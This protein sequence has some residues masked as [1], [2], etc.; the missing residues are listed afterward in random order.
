MMQRT[1]KPIHHAMKIREISFFSLQA[2]I[3]TIF[4]LLPIGLTLAIEEDGA[5]S[6][7]TRVAD[8]T[9]ILIAFTMLI[10]LSQDLKESVRPN[11]HAQ[12][13]KLELLLRVGAILMIAVYTFYQSVAITGGVEGPNKV[14]LDAWLTAYA[15][16]MLFFSILA[17]FFT[18]RAL[19]PHFNRED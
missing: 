5:S 11:I 3:P 10:S 9:I 12:V 17:C 1:R 15:F 19:R 6:A 14:L 4:A 13:E 18:L 2:I 16:V 7:V 8:G